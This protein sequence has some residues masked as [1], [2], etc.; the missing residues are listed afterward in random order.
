VKTVNLT[1]EN[2]SLFT[3]PVESTTSEMRL[4]IAALPAGIYIIAI[5]ADNKL[6]Y[7]KFTK[8]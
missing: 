1:H 5:P 8:K 3:E 2:G 6:H 4:K 7:R